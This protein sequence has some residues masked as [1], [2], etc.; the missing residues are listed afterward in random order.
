MKP[1]LILA[2]TLLAT[3]AFA[4]DDN[5]KPAPAK[6]PAVETKRGIVFLAHGAA[7][8][9]AK[10]LAS[11]FKGDA[12][13]HAGPDGS[14]NCLLVSAPTHVFDDVVATIER[15]DRQPQSVVVE[16]LIVELQSKFPADKT[17][18]AKDLTGS[19]ADVS[20]KLESMTKEGQLVGLKKF[21]LSAVEGQQA[22][23]S[24]TENKPYAMG[25]MMSG[26]GNVSTPITYRN[27][28]TQVR[29]SPLVMGDGSIKL[30]LSIEDS[31]ARDSSTAS[32]GT[33]EKGA[34]I[35]AADFVQTSLTAKV[36]VPPGQAVVAND[37]KTIS[38][39]GQGQT[40]IV[41]GARTK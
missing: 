34:P 8:D 32:V 14:A 5:G 36:S 27:I 39:A 21:Q 18:D 28:G 26:R 33:D 24:L 20:R 16:V 35:P 41:V 11:S 17:P 10:V 23:M 22:S 12:D 6:R 30:D 2:A 38:S 37:A 31:R 7:K 4:Q 40:L 1:A 25:A 13:I 19:F 9:M 29:V 15:L 3:A